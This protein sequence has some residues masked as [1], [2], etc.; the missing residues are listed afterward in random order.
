MTQPSND[1]FF[2]PVV[3]ANLGRARTSEANFA[4]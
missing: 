1:G 3:R 2:T 4:V